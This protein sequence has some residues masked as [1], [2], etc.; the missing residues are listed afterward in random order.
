MEARCFSSTLVFSSWPLPPSLNATSTPE[1]SVQRTTWSMT[2]EREREREKENTGWKQ[3]AET[4]FVRVY[5]EPLQYNTLQ[6]AHN[7]SMFVNGMPA[8]IYSLITEICN[9]HGQSLATQTPSFHRPRTATALCSLIS[10]LK[11]YKPA[12]EYWRRTTLSAE[13]WKNGSFGTRTE[14]QDCHHQLRAGKWRWDITGPHRLVK[15]SYRLNSVIIFTIYE[16]LMKELSL[17]INI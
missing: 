10:Y 8:L 13:E 12:L 2:R 6:R 17:E 15:K 4:C 7:V 14:D 11:L 5:S 1:L 16:R 3:N 9:R